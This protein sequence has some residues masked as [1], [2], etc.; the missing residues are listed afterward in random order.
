MTFAICIVCGTEKKRPID[1]CTKCGF[2]PKSDEEKAKSLML[3]T[4]YE[5]NGEYRGKTMEELKAIAA[6][7]QEKGQHEFDANEVQALIAYA[8]Q[9]M[10]IPAWRLIIDGLKWIVP[11]VAILVI[12]FVLLLMKR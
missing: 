9:V 1:K 8:H 10:A 2:K 6:E 4:A 12:V 3:S 7:I 5:I 11:P